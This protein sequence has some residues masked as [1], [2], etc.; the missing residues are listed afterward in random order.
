VR[1]N[2]F[3]STA[4][5]FYSF[6]TYK[7]TIP[8]KHF[9]YFD[10]SVSVVQLFLRTIKRNYENIS[11]CDFSPCIQKE[12]IQRLACDLESHAFHYY[13][14]TTSC[15][16]CKS[17]TAENINTSWVGV[18]YIQLGL[19]YDLFLQGYL[20]SLQGLYLATRLCST[21]NLA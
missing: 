10:A 16:F 21:L 8:L 7:K 18:P 4:Y 14:V 1:F 17:L 12:Q 6:Y 9:P 13:A 11:K 19:R 20:Q 3:Q 5:P 15:Q 2:M